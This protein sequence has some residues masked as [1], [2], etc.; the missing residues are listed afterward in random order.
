MGRY[1][2]N[3]K[4]TVE[5]TRQININWLLKAGHHDKKSRYFSQTVTWTRSG[6]WGE[7]KNS[8]SYDIDFSDVSKPNIRF[9]YTVTDR[10][11]QEKEHFDYTV[12]LTTTSCHL[13]GKRFWF[14]CPNQHCQKRVGSLYFGQKYFLCRHCLNLVYAS[15]NEDRRGRFVALGHMFDNE[16]KSE[17]VFEGMKRQQR[18]YRGKPTKRYERYLKYSLT[19]NQKARMWLQLESMM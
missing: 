8:I 7:S 9:R 10:D 18:F 11:T 2:F 1:Y 16:K 3:K 6:M 14:I 12:L 13:G 17:K 5:D 15:Q 19:A 4:D